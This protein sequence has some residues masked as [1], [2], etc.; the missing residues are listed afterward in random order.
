MSTPLL[1]WRPSTR[2]GRG[3]PEPGEGGHDHV[4]CV[5]GV[6]AIGG[7]VGEGADDLLEVPERPG[8]AVGED[9]G[10][11]VRTL[12]LLV[13]EVEGHALEVDLVVVE[14]VDAALGLAPVVLVTPRVE[15]RLEVLAVHAEAPVLVGE[16]GGEAGVIE[17]TVE[18][19]DGLVGDGDGEGLGLR[20][21]FPPLHGYWRGEPY[22]GGGETGELVPAVLQ[23]LA[24]AAVG[25]FVDAGGDALDKGRVVARAEQGAV[26]ALMGLDQLA[27]GGAIEMIGGL[28]RGAGRWPA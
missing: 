17:A 5:G 2:R 13:D 8:P 12:A 9:E 22:T 23:H 7:G 24:D 14:A 21:G 4:E 27:A 10:Q 6:A 1:V 19:L 26:V 20:H 11:G 15:E 28:R 16:V 25:H 3:E 18:V